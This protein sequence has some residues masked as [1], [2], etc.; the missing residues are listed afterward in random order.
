VV[1]C[2]KKFEKA[3]SVAMSICICKCG[4]L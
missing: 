3:I 4:S 1:G 2:E